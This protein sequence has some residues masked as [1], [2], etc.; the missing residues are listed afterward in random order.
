MHSIWL[1]GQSD[2]FRQSTFWFRTSVSSPVTLSQHQPRLL[3]SM[4]AHAASAFCSPVVCPCSA[5]L[6]EGASAPSL[7]TVAGSAAVLPVCSSSSWERPLPCSREAGG[8]PSVSSQSVPL[9]WAPPKS[10][11]WERRGGVQM[12]AATVAEGPLETGRCGAGLAP[13]G[14]AVGRWVKGVPQGV[15]KLA[16]PASK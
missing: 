1:W 5:L 10:R 4:V 14:A 9:G 15:L 6:R 2:P 13:P 12:A 8:T 16:R 11:Q 3:C 7:R